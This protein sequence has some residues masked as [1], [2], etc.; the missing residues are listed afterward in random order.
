MSKI[1]K[2][3]AREVLDS[4]GNPTVAAEVT[5][6]SGSVGSA[7][8]PSGA[9]T[10][11]REALE[12][13]DNDKSRYRG[14]G[15]L[16]AINNIRTRISPEIIGKDVT[17]QH[18]VDQTMIE[19]DGSDNKKNLGANA[20]LA[21]SMATARAAATE[22]G[23]PLYQYLGGAGPFDMPVPMM[24]IINGGA[25]ADNN[26][27]IQEFMIVPVGAP[28]LTEAVRYG[29]EVFHALKSV[30]SGKGL[31]TAGGD[32][33][34][35]APDLS[36]NAA[37]IEVILE[38]IAAAG[39]KAG[40]DIVLGLDAASSGFYRDGK[41]RL[42]SENREMSAEEFI[43]YLALWLDKYPIVTLEDAMAE[44]DWRGWK[45]M[46]ERLGGK[47]QLVGDDIFV[48]NTSI[49][50]RG[51]KEHIANSILIKVNQIGTLTETLAAI[52]MA[53]KAGYTA[54]ISHRSGETEDTIIADLAVATSV[55]QIKTGSLSRSDRVAKYNRLMK[56]EAELGSR[57][58]Y[59]GKK[60]FSNLQR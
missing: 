14:K 19:L 42:S 49:L 5:T 28:S 15:V 58:R 30:L 8:V 54:V 43:D 24:N 29:A 55:G 33:G 36:S 59:P 16:T 47:V 2:I 18:G 25:H 45:L 13:R 12:L 4:R 10:G 46:T 32:E 22:Q 17:D 39:F 11:I 37:A 41:Y 23:V 35:F 40:E 53:K 51:I 34:G 44:E 57:A 52:D 48:T 56:I 27:D 3:Q 9:S 20:I 1:T 50:S 60:A 6:A 7:M 38:A 21:V 26:V 31:S